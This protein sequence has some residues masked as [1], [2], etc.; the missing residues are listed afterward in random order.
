MTVHPM[1]CKRRSN[2]EFTHCY[3]DFYQQPLPHSSQAR[4]GGQRH[5]VFWL[6]CLF[7]FENGRCTFLHSGLRNFDDTCRAQ[8]LGSSLLALMDAF[9]APFPRSYRRAFFHSFHSTVD[10]KDSASVRSKPSKRSTANWQFSHS[11][12]LVHTFQVQ[13]RY[14]FYLASL[15]H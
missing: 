7:S 11:I 13:V 9:V 10:D 15:V 8:R 14:H 2:L 5:A 12:K 1:I 6:S 3:A 4:F